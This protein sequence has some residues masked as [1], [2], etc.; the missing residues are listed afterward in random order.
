MLLAVA[1]AQQV[2]VL[3]GDLRDGHVAVWQEIGHEEV[4]AEREAAL[5]STVVQE[6]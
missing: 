5:L 2:A 3:V 6:I 4:F 1:G